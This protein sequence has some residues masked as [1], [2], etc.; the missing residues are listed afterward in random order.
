[1]QLPVSQRIRNGRMDTAGCPDGRQQPRKSTLL[2]R[3][4]NPP[5][6]DDS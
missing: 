5:I 6:G 1:M 2:Q 4:S 3:Q